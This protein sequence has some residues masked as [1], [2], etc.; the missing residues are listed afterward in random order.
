MSNQEPMPNESPVG[1]GGNGNSDP[2]GQSGHSGY[3]HT[4][5]FPPTGNEQFQG[6]APD[7]RFDSFDD[8]K[9]MSAP[10]FRSLLDLSFSNFITIKFASFIY[11]FMII[12]IAIGYLFAVIAAF[13]QDFL[14]GVGVLII[15]VPIALV[16]VVLVRL[17]LELSVAM[18][19]TAQNTSLLVGENPKR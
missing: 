12:F 10:F 16:Y 11:V 18:V 6:G 7:G 2:A 8:A 15:G 14:A 13:S 19:R 5:G 9:N 4:Q 1:P 3:A 17:G